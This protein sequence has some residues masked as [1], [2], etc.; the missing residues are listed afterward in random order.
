MDDI[1]NKLMIFLMYIKAFGDL[2]VD[3]LLGQV[4]KR[5]LQE[6]GGFSRI[7]INDYISGR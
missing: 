5:Y 6:V 3:A 4:S 7:K 1:L 2:F